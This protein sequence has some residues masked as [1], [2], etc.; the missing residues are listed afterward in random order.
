MLLEIGFI[1]EMRTHLANE[2]VPETFLP[3]SPSSQKYNLMRLS[4][5]QFVTSHQA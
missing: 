2:E 3:N 1:E 5:Y 4:A